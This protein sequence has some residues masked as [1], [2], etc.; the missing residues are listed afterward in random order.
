MARGS[1]RGGHDKWT[2]RTNASDADLAPASLELD[3]DTDSTPFDLAAVQHDDALIDAIAGGGK[4]A[5][6][7]PE[8]YQLAMLLA[9]WRAE[10]VTPALPAEPSL[11]E[12]V[13]AVNEEIAPGTGRSARLR[14]LRPIA[15]A[16]A[17]I[18]VVMAGVT[19]FSYNAQPGD[20]LWKVKEVVFSQ[21]ANSTVAGIDTTS[22]LQEAERLIKAGDTQGAMAVL[23]SA[24]K[25][26]GDVNDSGKRD[27]LNA[28]HDRLMADVAKTTTSTTTA[29]TTTT[30]PGESTSVPVVP[31][32]TIPGLPSTSVPSI[33]PSELTVVPI[34]PTAPSVTPPVVT[35]PSQVPTTT[36]PSQSQSPSPSSTTTSA[37]AASTTIKIVPPIETRQ[38]VPA[39][40]PS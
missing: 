31:G 17:A 27:E 15:G 32:V 34:V 18:A 8:E 40:T 10:I 1:K 16:A 36:E 30:T 37:P 9:G 19:V 21:R 25:R 38:L 24:S 29:T 28:W 39:P 26:V 33:P 7:T 11:D 13:A 3:E 20:P 12:V 23:Q 2:Q 4:V 6:E 5:T 35:T 14:L 22:N